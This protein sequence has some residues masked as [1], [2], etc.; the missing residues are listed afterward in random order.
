[1]VL[2]PFALP[3]VTIGVVSFNRLRYLRALLLSARECIDYPNIQ[4]I[5]VD[6]NSKESGL[7]E[8]LESQDW[9]QHK[10]YKDCSHAEAMNAIVSLAEGEF[11]MILPEDVQFVVRGPWMK[12]LVEVASRHSDIGN[13]AFNFHRRSTVNWLFGNS[14]LHIRWGL[15]RKYIRLP[16]RRS[17][18]IER[19]SQDMSFFGMGNMREAICG[20]GIMSF[21]RTQTWRDLGPWRTTNSNVGNDSS[22][23]AEDDM[24][25]RYF[26]SGLWLEN[27]M[28]GIPV[29]ADIVTDMAGT[30]ARV[31]GGN[32]RYGRYL[33]APNGKT[34]YRIMDQSDLKAGALPLAFEDWVEPEGFDLPFDSQG[35]LLK[36][37]GVNLNGSFELIG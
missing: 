30:K 13:I 11:L 29:C 10:I 27:F 25:L 24:V 7:R 6:G 16:W 35:N 18:R 21:M 34:Y 23:G 1:M 17:V 20:S 22:L 9:I 4:W 14:H 28:M 37:A 8:F 5:V 19:S 32:K 2:P 12:S 26:N 33:E 31:R 15:K 3:R 36:A